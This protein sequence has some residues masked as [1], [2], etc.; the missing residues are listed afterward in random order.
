MT[1][2]DVLA[3]LRRRWVVVLC[4]ILATSALSGFA[5]SRVTPSLEM[6]SSV[7]LVPG[8]ATIVEGGNP[9]LYLGGLS[10][11]RDV[12]VRVLAA[13]EIHEW[14]AGEGGDVVFAADVMTSSPV[15]TITVTGSTAA[16]ARAIQD[17][18]LAV[19]TDE[20][21][22]L[23]DQYNVVPAAKATILVLASDTE[24][25]P[26]SRM[27]I[28]AAGAVAAMGLVATV[29]I[30]AMIDGILLARPTRRPRTA[31]VSRRRPGPKDG[32]REE[33]PN[34]VGRHAWAR[35]PERSNT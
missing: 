4:G 25:T 13:D 28:R 30:T 10:Q 22:G 7:V 33:A 9:F 3:G 26:N 35:S 2:R 5:W 16:G 34:L 14:A 20:L 31:S 19:V 18:A 12:L 32:G 11:A 17:R 6:S 21:D 23:Q 29:L 1:A 27:R 24:P 15:V 8:R